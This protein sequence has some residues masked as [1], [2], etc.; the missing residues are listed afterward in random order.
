M[1]ETATPWEA[2]EIVAEI[3]GKTVQTVEGDQV[4][5]ASAR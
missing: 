2:D 4:L 3:R 1:M 5:I